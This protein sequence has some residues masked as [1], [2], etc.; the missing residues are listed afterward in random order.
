MKL[1]FP[2]EFF[3]KLSN[4][5][6]HEI[7]SSGSQV[8]SCGWTD[9]Q[10]DMTK[11]RA[12]FRN[13]ENAPKNANYQQLL[14]NPLVMCTDIVASVFRGM[15]RILTNITVT[16]VCACETFHKGFPLDLLSLI[17]KEDCVIK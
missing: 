7:P 14:L 1:E 6:F 5:K 10:T 12:S 15:S 11:L 3:E 16:R 8:V 17:C 4:I 2:R 9:G 13:F